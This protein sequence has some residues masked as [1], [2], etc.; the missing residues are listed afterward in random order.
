MCLVLF[1][2]VLAFILIIIFLKDSLVLV[3]F[4]SSVGQIK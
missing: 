4:Y 2:Y 1:S 3:I